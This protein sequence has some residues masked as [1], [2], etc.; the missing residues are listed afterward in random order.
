MSFIV[1]SLVQPAATPPDGWMDGWVG[2]WMDGGDT[3][4]ATQ[5]QTHTARDSVMHIHGFLSVHAC[6]TTEAEMNT[7]SCT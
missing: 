4:S 5:T 3:A 2:G 1:P 6:R 7:Q